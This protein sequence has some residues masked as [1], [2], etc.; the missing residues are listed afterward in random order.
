MNTGFRH[1]LAQGDHYDAVVVLDGDGQHLP[2]EIP[3]FA[4]KFAETRAAAIVGTRMD[5]TARMPL[6]RRLTNRFMSGLLSRQMGQ[7]IPDTQCGFRLYRRDVLPLLLEHGRFAGFAADS[8]ALLLISLEGHAIPSVR[9]STVYGDERSKIHPAR[10]TIR[11][12]RLLLHFR[13]VRRA[14]EKAKRHA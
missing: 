6:V 12:I 3:A 4:A 11:F 13:A 5:D 10:D 14:H 9:V 8:E 7:R 1:V 2:E